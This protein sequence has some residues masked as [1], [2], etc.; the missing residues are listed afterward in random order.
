MSSRSNLRRREPEIVSTANKIGGFGVS[1]SVQKEESSEMEKGK[2]RAS[3][4]CFPFFS[5]CSV[6]KGSHPNPTCHPIV[7]P[8]CEGN[9]THFLSEHFYDYDRNVVLED[10]SGAGD[11]R[12]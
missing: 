1:E 2:Q 6:A 11:Y 5:C 9:I 3:Y 12:R 8:S 4:M 7:T 10:V